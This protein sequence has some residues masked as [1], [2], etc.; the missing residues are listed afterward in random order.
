M[1]QKWQ[2]VGTFG[3]G[4]A[5]VPG[6]EFFWPL[7]CIALGDSAN[8]IDLADLVARSSNMC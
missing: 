2:T 4:I 1:V 8:I 7:G 5:K 3:H 6:R